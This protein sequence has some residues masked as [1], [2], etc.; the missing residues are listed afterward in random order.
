MTPHSNSLG[1]KRKENTLKS[2]FRIKK[3]QLLIYYLCFTLNEMA[4]TQIKKYKPLKAPR[5]FSPLSEN[6]Q[7]RI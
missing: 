5:R 7:K 1:Q 6:T 3:L 4:I 2:F